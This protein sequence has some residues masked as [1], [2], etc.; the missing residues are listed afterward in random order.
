MKE[1][2]FCLIDFQKCRSRRKWI[3]VGLTELISPILK[4]SDKKFMNLAE[5]QGTVYTEQGF[6]DAFNLKYIYLPCSVLRIIEVENHESEK[7]TR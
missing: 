2:R 6:V 7:L 5:K 3:P 4:L 1:K